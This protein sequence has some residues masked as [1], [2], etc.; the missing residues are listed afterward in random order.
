MD[1]VKERA[2]D[3]RGRYRLEKVCLAHHVLDRVLGVANEA[4]RCRGLVRRAT[5]VERLVCEIVLHRVDEHGVGCPPLLLLELVPCHVVPITDKS[6]RLPLARNLDEQ[7]CARYVSAAHQDTIRREVLEHMAL[8]CTLR[9][10]FHKVVVVL[11]VR[12]KP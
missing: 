2:L 7:S 1:A 5:S 6:K 11:H 4:H 9:P 3:E 12:Q 8:A 10:K